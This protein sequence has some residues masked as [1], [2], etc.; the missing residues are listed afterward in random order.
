MH[1][2]KDIADDRSLASP[3]RRPGLR[4]LFNESP[5]GADGSV[6]DLDV[7]G[8]YRDV[9]YL[10]LGDCRNETLDMRTTILQPS[11]R[12]V[13]PERLANGD[14]WAKPARVGGRLGDGGEGLAGS[15]VKLRQGLSRLKS[16]TI[17][18]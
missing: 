14:T 1:D 13:A 11:G 3:R 16:F 12:G 17:G 7:E 2:A 10:R 8:Q 6:T 5:G 4:H 15:L 18:L 9:L